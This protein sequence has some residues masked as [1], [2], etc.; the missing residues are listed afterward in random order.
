MALGRQPSCRFEDDADLV[1]GPP[2]RAATAGN[3]IDHQIEMLRQSEGSGYLQCRTGL[4]EV[5][6]RTF[7]LW[8][9]L[10]QDD[11]AALESSAAEGHASFG[12]RGP[13]PRAK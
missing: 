2:L 8:C 12:H 5:A 3:A 7:E 6:H 1:V 13:T 9:F 10:A 4:R 11:K